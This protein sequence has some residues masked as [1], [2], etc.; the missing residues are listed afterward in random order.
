MSVNMSCETPRLDTIQANDTLSDYQKRLAYA[1]SFLFLLAS[2]LGAI[3]NTIVILVTIRFRRLRSSPYNVLVLNLATV[4]LLA[5]LISAPGGFALIQ[6]FLVTKTHQNTLCTVLVFLHNLSVWSSLTIMSEIAVFRVVSI[7]SCIN[8]RRVLTKRFLHKTVAV[9]SVIVILFSLFRVLGKYNVCRSLP[10][11][12]LYVLINSCILII[13][14]FIIGSTHAWIAWYINKRTKQIAEAIRTRRI[15]DNRY[16][17]ATIRACVLIAVLFAI[18][19]FPYISYLILVMENV[20]DSSFPSYVIYYV[21]TIFVHVG[22]PVIMFCTSS[23][24][25]HHVRKY[26]KLH[27]RNRRVHPVDVVL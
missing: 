27:K 21:F 22:N 5:S 11:P 16:S 1:T 6:V 14:I 24:F 8:A 23:D 25:K 2:V 4:D 17:I 19:H 18:C 10:H 7:S 9:S 20:I 15:P 12:S 13:F 26:F 3:F